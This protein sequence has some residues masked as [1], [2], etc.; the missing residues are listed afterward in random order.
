MPFGSRTSLK[1][2]DVGLSDGGTIRITPH[3]AHTGDEAPSNVVGFLERVVV[4]VLRLLA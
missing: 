2:S 1:K 3:D 4:S